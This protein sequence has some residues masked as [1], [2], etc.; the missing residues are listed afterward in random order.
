MV[1]DHWE[2]DNVHIYEYDSL[3]RYPGMDAFK[4][5]EG[6]VYSPEGRACI[7]A[8]MVVSAQDLRAGVTAQQAIGEAR[9][10]L[11][12]LIGPDLAGNYYD[13]AKTATQSRTFLHS[14]S[15]QL[16]RQVYP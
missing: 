15:G 8:V 2:G 6:Y 14:W 9:R 16:V 5:A 12:Q 4:V 11:R 1:T 13:A 3:E 10:R 7:G